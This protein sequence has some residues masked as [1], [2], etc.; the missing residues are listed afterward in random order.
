MS[1]LRQRTAPVYKSVRMLLPSNAVS[2]GTLHLTSLREQN[3]H[4]GCLQNALFPA[5][6]TLSSPLFKT[7]IALPTHGGRHQLC[8]YTKRTSARLIVQYALHKRRR[9][10]IALSSSTHGLTAAPKS[11]S[12]TSPT[13]AISPVQPVAY[14]YETE[15]AL[16]EEAASGLYY[17]QQ[18]IVASC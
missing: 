8:T 4:G 14:P 10:S 13:Y 2:V 12:N 5:A 16:V 15:A 11:Q 9:S 17:A 7:I 1:T 6:R 18:F 3:T